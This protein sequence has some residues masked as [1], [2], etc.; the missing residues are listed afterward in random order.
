[1]KIALDLGHGVPYD[2]GAI[3]I[4]NEEKVVRG[5]GPLVIS[6]L[7]A[8]GHEVLNV[9]PS[10]ATSLGNS[11]SQRTT[12]ANNWG[13]D[14]FVCCHANSFSAASASGCEVE[15]LSSGGK[16]YA[17][18]IVNEIAKLG[19]LNRGSV[20]RKNLYVINHTNMPAVIIEPLFVTNSADC[21]RYNPENIANAIVKGITGQTVEKPKVTIL[22][23]TAQTPVISDPNTVVTA[24]K[25][26]DQIT[27][28][29]SET[30]NGIAYWI[31]DYNGTKGYVP[32]GNSIYK[33]N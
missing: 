30:I 17:D 32:A 20:L 33:N 14:L 5:Y 29:G 12:A 13:A 4:L 9:T 2:G 18:K 21:S 6:K 25:K 11:L 1:M 28:H 31:I 23:I 26:G 7:Q 24:Y 27:A 15:Y 16:I 3:G 10:T 22:E 19:Y 8:L